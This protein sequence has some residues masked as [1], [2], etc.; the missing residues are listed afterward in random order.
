MVLRHVRTFPRQVGDPQAKD[1]LFIWM[2]KYL[3]YVRGRGHTMQTLW[4]TER[5][6]RDFIAWCDRQKI[7]VPDQ[8][9]RQVMERY[10]LSLQEHRTRK[11]EPLAWHSKEAKL[12]PVRSFFRWL[13]D[14]EERLQ[15]NPATQLKL[16]RRPPG[17]TVVVPGA[18][19]IERILERPNVCLPI[20]IRDRAMLETL[21]ST[22]L[23]RMELANL[24]VADVDA[25]AR[26]LSVRNGKGGKSRTIPIAERALT[27]IRKYIDEAR[28]PARADEPILF[29]TERGE[30]FNLS[31]LTTTIGAHVHAATGKSI[32]SCHLLR[33]FMATHMLRGGADIRHV[34]AQLGHASIGTTQLYTHVD[35]EDLQKVYRQAHPSARVEEPAAGPK[36]QPE[37]NVAPTSSPAPVQSA[38]PTVG[39]VFS[40]SHLP[41]IKDKLS[42]IL[43]RLSPSA[44][45]S[46]VVHIV[47]SSQLVE[48]IQRGIAVDREAKS[49][50]R[51]VPPVY[52]FDWAAS[53]YDSLGYPIRRSGP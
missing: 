12:V 34:Q 18:E 35:T 16:A 8:V 14:V 52:Q 4:G 25:S 23:R 44:A 1:G 32:G 43:G 37:E 41:T 5:Y 31:W 53:A 6:L 24:R 36:V 19:A 9:T 20:G 13:C 30:P 15:K 28:T 10:L 29:L 45:W 40:E 33:H 38:S 50:A 46:D 3:D 39:R 48:D 7:G 49:D 51:L 2:K 27:W 26:F 21:F 11:G 42:A 47:A 22:G 17:R